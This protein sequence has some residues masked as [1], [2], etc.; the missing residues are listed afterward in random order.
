MFCTGK[1]AES[2]LDWKLKTLKSQMDVSALMWKNRVDIV[3]DF[4]ILFKCY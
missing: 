4:I 1:N 3:I 2:G